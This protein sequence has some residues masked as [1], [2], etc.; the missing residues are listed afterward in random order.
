MSWKPGVLS[1]GSWLIWLKYIEELEN[2]WGPEVQVGFTET[3]YVPGNMLR[4]LH[5]WSHLSPTILISTAATN[6]LFPDPETNIENPYSWYSCERQSIWPNPGYLVPDPQPYPLC[7][8]SWWPHRL[9]VSA[10]A[11]A[12]HIW[13]EGNFGWGTHQPRLVPKK[14]TLSGRFLP[15]NLRGCLPVTWGSGNGGHFSS[16]DFLFYTAALLCLVPPTKLEPQQ[17]LLLVWKDW[18]QTPFRYFSKSSKLSCLQIITL[19]RSWGDLAAHCHECIERDG[20]WWESDILHLKCELNCGGW[21][22]AT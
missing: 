5:E 22:E 11:N 7:A 3:V 15:F 4:E 13:L 1:K 21:E 9:L 8:S 2:E 17:I 19:S 14:K 20:I 12:Q 16:K 18:V 10:F 6:C